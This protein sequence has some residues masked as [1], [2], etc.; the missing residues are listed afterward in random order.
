MKFLIKSVLEAL[1]YAHSIGIFHRDI[2]PQNILT[3]SEFS[4]IIHFKLDCKLIDW[5]LAEFY[6]PNKD[7][8]TRVAS[9]FFKS[10]EILLDN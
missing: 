9:R 8:N 4:C 2:K 5:G 1:D 10:P 6:H 7:Y 3:D